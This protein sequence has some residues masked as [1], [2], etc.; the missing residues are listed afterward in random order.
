MMQEI[1]KKFMRVLKNFRKLQN[2][3]FFLLK[4]F[5]LAAK[6]GK[7]IIVKVFWHAPSE[8]I[9]NLLLKSTEYLRQYFTSTNETNT[10]KS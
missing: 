5:F 8:K 3:H 9:K 10:G 4:L 6:I 7:V 2:F 1:E